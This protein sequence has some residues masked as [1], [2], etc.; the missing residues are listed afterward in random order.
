ME[1]VDVGAVRH[2]LDGLDLTGAAQRGGRY[3]IDQVYED[4]STWVS[5]GVSGQLSWPS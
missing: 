2:Y 1:G 3:W 4:V 5:T